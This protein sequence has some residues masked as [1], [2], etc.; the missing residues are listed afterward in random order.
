MC[1]N[2]V[3]TIRRDFMRFHEGRCNTESETRPAG[4]STPRVKPGACF[5]LER[6]AHDQCLDMKPRY[7]R[8]GPGMIGKAGCK[9]VVFNGLRVDALPCFMR[10]LYQ[11][12]PSAGSPCVTWGQERL[13]SSFLAEISL[14]VYP[15]CSNLATLPACYSF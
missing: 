14:D 12:S 7:M 8:Q 1:P 10:P 4:V 11:Q 9:G 15:S 13:A 5:F 2:H 6:D 3:K